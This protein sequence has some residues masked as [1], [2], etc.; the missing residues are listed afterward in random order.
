[1]GPARYGPVVKDGDG[2]AMET[3]G[4]EW[5]D[6]LRLPPL[7]WIVLR[8]LGIV[9]VAWFASAIAD[10]VADIDL[11]TIDRPYLIVAAVVVFDAIVP[12]FPSESLLNTG[13]I[14]ATQDDSTI[15]IWRL[16][17][18][19]SVGA[20]VGDTLLYGLSRSVMRNF[21]AERLE[22][23]QRNE[24]VAE[25]VGVLQ[26][27]APML[28][29]GGR[30]VPGVRFVVGATMGLTRYP[31]PRFLLWDAIG[32]I[33]W[34][35]FACVSSAVISTAVGGQPVVSIVLSA[36]ITTALLGFLYQ[37][38]KRSLTSSASTSSAA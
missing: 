38:L 28:I 11:E 27:E 20:V 23:A 17:V 18:A 29:I 24:R 5:S 25:A 35:S 13:S 9:A 15:E 16:I 14:L 21:M 7:R 1:M 4:A 33:A 31:F 26:G 6:R 30:F 10:R 12:I 32:G 3:G 2:K 36:I 22:Q 37:R 34:A 8:G 19:G